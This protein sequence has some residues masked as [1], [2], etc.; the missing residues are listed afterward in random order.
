LVLRP[1]NVEGLMRCVAVGCELLVWLMC[2]TLRA[3]PSAAALFLT[4]DEVRVGQ[5]I[6]TLVAN[7]IKYAC[8][9]SVRLRAFRISEEEVRIEVIDSGTGIPL[10]QLSA[11][12]APSAQ[13]PGPCPV[14]KGA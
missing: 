7:A 11:L 5:V 9:G 10:E 13:A 4:T 2:L 6:R 12:F 1:L 14:A 3:E 8:E